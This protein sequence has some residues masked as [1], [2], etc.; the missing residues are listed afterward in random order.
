ME[1]AARSDK[2]LSPMKFRLPLLHVGSFRPADE[3]V[4]ILP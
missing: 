2:T 3:T 1:K 4:G